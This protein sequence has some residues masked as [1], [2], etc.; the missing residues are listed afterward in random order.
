MKSYPKNILDINPKKSF[1]EGLSLCHLP[2]KRF[3]KLRTSN[4][5]ALLFCSQSRIL[6]RILLLDL[7]NPRLGLAWRYLHVGFSI[8]PGKG[9]DSKVYRAI[10]TK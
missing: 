1:L 9:V 4:L 3:L 2:Q 10:V 6:S 5:E 7:A 8:A